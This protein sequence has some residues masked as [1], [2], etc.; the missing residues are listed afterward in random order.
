VQRRAAVAA[1]SDTQRATAAQNTET[2]KESM[3]TT[4]RRGASEHHKAPESAFDGED[5]EGTTTDGRTAADSWQPHPYAAE[6]GGAGGGTRR[7][8]RRQRP[9]RG[10]RRRSQN[11]A[12]A[13]NVSREGI[14]QEL[15]GL[16]RQIR[17]E[18]EES[19]NRP[20]EEISAI[21]RTV[22]TF[23]KQLE[24][25]GDPISER[26]RTEYQRLREI[27]TQR[28]RGEPGGGEPGAG[29]AGK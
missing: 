13:E 18:A 2:K 14:F 3:M 5:R 24:E 29:E 26:L 6:V 9:A 15:E 23:T 11:H 8:R 19:L 17:E 10:K 16:L 7:K 20:E 28:L 1:A 4:T 12:Q 21:A 27:L 22:S 25:Q